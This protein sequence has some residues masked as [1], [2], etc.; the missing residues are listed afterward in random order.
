MS[1]EATFQEIRV[2]RQKKMTLCKKDDAKK[3]S[4]CKFRIYGRDIDN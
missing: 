1:N 2:I 3:M 4:L